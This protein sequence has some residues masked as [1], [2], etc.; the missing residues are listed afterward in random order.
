MKILDYLKDNGFDVISV[1]KINDIFAGKGIT[2]AIPTVSNDDGMKKTLELSKRDFEGLCFVNLVEFDSHYGHRNNTK[3][4][5][6]ALNAFDLWLQS[7]LLQLRQ[8]DILIITADHGCDPETE[9]T[10]HSREYTPLIVYG[11][12]VKS[13][14]LGTR[15][16]FA[17]T[18]KTVLDYFGV[19][20]EVYGL[21]YLGNIM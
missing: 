16:T 8:D 11:E 14:D 4:Y 15:G 17:D 20:N 7:F 5:A 12:R 13:V 6:E 3:G 10:D 18:G 9:S 1:G 2:E 19:D 21:S